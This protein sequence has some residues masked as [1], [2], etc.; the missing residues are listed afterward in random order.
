MFFG[1]KAMTRIFI[2]TLALVF[3][4]SMFAQ[5]AEPLSA[6]AKAGIGKALAEIGCTPSADETTAMGD[7]YNVEYAKCKDGEYGIKLDKNFKII[8]K[9][10]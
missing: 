2:T 3:T 5:A 1:G 4:A 9:K 7:G 10:K 6:E 8:E